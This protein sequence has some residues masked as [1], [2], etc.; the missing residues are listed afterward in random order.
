MTASDPVFLTNVTADRDGAF[1]VTVTIPA[2]VPPGDHRIMAV[3]A[4]GSVAVTDA[5]VVLPPAPASGTTPA[6]ALAQSGSETP[7]GG[8]ALGGMLLLVGLALTAL[9]RRANS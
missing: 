4:D 7:W 2:T 8:L 9:R 5:V 6:A 1:Q 3:R